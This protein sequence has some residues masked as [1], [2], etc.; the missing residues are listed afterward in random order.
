MPVAR[1]DGTLVRWISIAIQVRIQNGI[2]QFNHG[3]GTIIAGIPKWQIG[4]PAEAA[5]ALL[6]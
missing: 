4:S 3:E 2:E 5:G 6:E 1:H